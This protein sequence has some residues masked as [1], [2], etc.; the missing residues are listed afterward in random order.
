VITG[1]KNWWRGGPDIAKIT[2]TELI[3]NIPDSVHKARLWASKLTDEVAGGMDDA[4]KAID[5]EIGEYRVAAREA[6]GHLRQAENQ[7]IKLEEE[8]SSL[9][10]TSKHY[11]RLADDAEQA[12]HGIA[13]VND[14][15]MREKGYIPVSRQTMLE[16][17]AIKSRQ[18]KRQAQRAAEEARDRAKAVTRSQD[19]RNTA[20]QNYDIA[21]SK[22]K[23]LSDYAHKIKTFPQEVAKEIADN[24]DIGRNFRSLDNWFAA[25]TNNINTKNQILKS[26]S[27]YI[28]SS[29]KKF[30]SEYA[31]E[32]YPGI[33]KGDRISM[34][35]MANPENRTRLA[36][37]ARNKKFLDKIMEL[38]H[39]KE[40][41][42]SLRGLTKAQI[43]RKLKIAGVAGAGLT[44]AIAFMTWF[45]E[46]G[47]NIEEGSSKAGS[48]IGGFEA[49][50]LG[51]VILDETKK[52][53]ETI[54]KAT[55]NAEVELGKNPKT[56]APNYIKILVQ[57]K[58]IIDKN[59]GRW[60]VVIRSATDKNAAIAAGE[61]LKSYSAD[62]E[63]QLNDVGKLTGSLERPGKTVEPGVAGDIRKKPMSME[64]IKG[65]Q[66]WLSSRFPTVAP[67]GTL[68]QPTI[69]ALKMLEREYDRLGTTDRFSSGRLLVRPDEGHM[70]EV[71]DLTRL[72]ERM[73]KYK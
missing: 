23:G 24:P 12:A 9:L 2:K 3:E 10:K 29:D 36:F 16:N 20:K 1:I 51:A 22:H 11:Q 26:T 69:R 62:L 32:V 18:Y 52:A 5:R 38:E 21:S 45:D 58:A 61:V 59:L 70:I 54:N 7:L 48:D 63:R 31:K 4:V 35:W 67:T 27:R 47:D 33:K 44:G 28:R 71:S 73:Q 6:Y 42:E 40:F 68:D 49:S 34:L 14:D 30:F 55:K 64:Q 39:G 43:A 19:I 56:V 53:I 37:L 46:E 60:D 13:R 25:A 17:Q 65:V 66:N 72:D 8:Y 15:I 41:R 50:G 57:Q